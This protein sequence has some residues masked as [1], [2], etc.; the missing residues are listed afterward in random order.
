MPFYP[1]VY[2]Y[3]DTALSLICPV[4]A[5]MC[6]TCEFDRPSYV[7]LFE[8]IHNMQTYAHIHTQ[9]QLGFLMKGHTHE[10]VDAL[11]GKWLQRHDATTLPGLFVCII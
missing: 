8:C 9:I 10:D 4:L 7:L 6:Y 11:F 3:Q 2:H 5:C 1:L